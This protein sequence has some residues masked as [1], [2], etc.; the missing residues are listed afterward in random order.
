MCSKCQSA[1]IHMFKYWSLVIELEL[2]M[3]CFVWSLHEG[4]FLLYVQVCDQL[5]AWFFALDHTNYARLLLI[6][7]RVASRCACW[8]SHWK[9]H[10]SKIPSKIQPHSKR[11]I[12]RTIKQSTP[13]EWQSLGLIWQHRHNSFVYLSWS[14]LCQKYWRVWTCS[15]ATGII[16]WSPWGS[17]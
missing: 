3:C 1:D 10:G 9:F 6:H 11:S 17:T 8:V 16:S 7:V 15:Q 5:C 12:T 14:R 2:L 13:G 4:D